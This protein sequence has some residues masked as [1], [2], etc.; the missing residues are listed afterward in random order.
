MEKSSKMRER[1]EERET[2]RAKRKEK[3]KERRESEKEKARG[4]QIVESER[5]KKEGSEGKKD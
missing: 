2:L 4:N 1:T 5:R 3:R